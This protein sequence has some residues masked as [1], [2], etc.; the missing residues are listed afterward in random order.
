[1]KWHPSEE[2]STNPMIVDMLKYNA[3]LLPMGALGALLTPLTWLK[4]LPKIQNL[5]PYLL[6]LAMVGARRKSP[7]PNSKNWRGILETIGLYLIPA[8]AV[9]W[10]GLSASISRDLGG[11]SF[12]V[13]FGG[14]TVFR[15]RVDSVAILQQWGLT[16]GHYSDKA[17]R[18]G[19]TH[20]KPN[21][22]QDFGLFQ[23]ETGGDRIELYA[24]KTDL[25]LPVI[26][27]TFAEHTLHHLFPSVDHAYHRHLYPV[28]AQTCNE[29]GVRFEFVS[30]VEAIKGFFRELKRTKPLETSRRV[31]W[32]G[33]EEYGW[34]D[35]K[36]GFKRDPR[37]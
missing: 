13:G 15:Q 32:D 12:L 14:L 27:S 30:Q 21:E 4:K 18:Q 36:M 6:L 17:W 11:V 5:L 8:M 29:F 25:M 1:M 33:T 9:P 22:I 37:K 26:L 19:E 24:P 3:K 31:N 35:E 10:W 2:R 16:V 7:L 20:P 28:F 23:L 34:V